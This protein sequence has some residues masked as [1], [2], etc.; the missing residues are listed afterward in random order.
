M[1]IVVFG[2]TGF[3]GKVLCHEL[4]GRDREVIAV[5]KKKNDHEFTEGW[6][7]DI[8]FEHVGE[9]TW[10][11]SMRSLAHGGRLVTCGATTGPKARI[12]IR[13][14]F[15]KQ[16]TIMGSTMGDAAAFTELLDL[17]EKGALKPILDRTFPMSDAAEAHRYIEE[18]KQFGK[19]VLMPY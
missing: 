14:L 5:G 2:G 10:P 12:E 18:G 16:Q 6:G 19:V 13:H 15:H 9:A 8:V 4:A 17:L 1:K 3:I 7:A 11:S